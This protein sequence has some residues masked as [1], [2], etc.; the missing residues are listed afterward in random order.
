MLHLMSMTTQTLRADGDSFAGRLSERAGGL[1]PAEQRVAEHLLSGGTAVLVRSAAKIAADLG[2]SDATVVRTAQAL[3]YR[4]F[5]ELKAA[6]A[7]HH[8]ELTLSER[9][10]GS[11]SEASE[12]SFLTSSID[13][14][15]EALE[16]L[17]RRVTGTEFERAVD[18]AAA[19]DRVVWC[20]IGPSAHLAGYA[21][22][23]GNR[24][25]S[26][27]TAFVHSGSDFA[28]ELITMRPT[29][30]VV[31]LAYGRL[32]HHVVVLLERARIIG[33]PVILVTD[34]TPDAVQERV[35]VVLNAGRGKP[36]LF[37]S[38]ATTTLLL[39]AFVLGLAA[40]DDTHASDQLEDLNDVRAALA[41]R[42]LDVDPR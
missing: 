22:L 23:L 24:V 8:D 27:S 13:Q 9:L 25:G 28:D 39:E 10:R 35:D 3:G 41:G 31:V 26:P 37:A 14:Q 12:G 40:R 1:S 20:G 7:A 11:L 17:G 6:V 16:L 33:A 30:A 29:D 32:H 19:A 4:G 18:L 38:H 34:R 15:I 5:G 2:L 42:R 21:A 36:G